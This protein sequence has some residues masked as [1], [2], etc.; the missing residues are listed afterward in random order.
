[1]EGKSC[2]DIFLEN[3]DALLHYHVSAYKFPRERRDNIIFFLSP[4][5]PPPA[6]LSP[7]LAVTGAHP[8]EHVLQRW[9]ILHIN[10]LPASEKWE[11]GIQ[12]TLFAQRTER[13][14][15]RER[16][17]E[18]ST[19]IRLKRALRLSLSLSSRCSCAR[20]WSVSKFPVSD[21][22]KEVYHVGLLNSLW[23]V[24]GTRRLG[25]NV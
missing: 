19:W 2:R 25:R 12:G 20:P 18:N 4:P 11:T 23:I 10:C 21:R 5:P 3:R 13:K 8:L 6:S 16:E 7:S 9:L 24:D 17:R 15:G 22:E 1:M 14:R